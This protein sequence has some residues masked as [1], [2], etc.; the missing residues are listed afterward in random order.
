MSL[1]MWS[2]L[3]EIWYCVYK[4]TAALEIALFLKNEEAELHHLSWVL[5]F[6]TPH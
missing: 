4:L 6:R 5:S 3:L 1:R 2:I